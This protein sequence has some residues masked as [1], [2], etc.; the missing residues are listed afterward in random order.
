MTLLASEA[1]W[2]L[3]V[4]LVLLCSAVLLAPAAN[5]LDNGVALRP[6]L[7]YS[8]WN[9]FNDAINDTLIRDLGTSLISTGLAAA[10]YRTLNIDAGYLIHERHPT[11]QRLQ[12]N[13]TKFPHGMRA[14]ADFLEGL[15]P[16]IATTGTQSI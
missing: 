14:L 16:P 11:T 10:G 5:A 6:F 2:S 12:V 4:S 9:F 15:D 13:S 7:G 1:S 8:T 3:Q